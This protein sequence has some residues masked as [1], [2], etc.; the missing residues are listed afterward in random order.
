VQ[1]YLFRV[2]YT[3]PDAT[4]SHESVCVRADNETDAR[5][6]VDEATERYRVAAGVTKALTL[7][8]VTADV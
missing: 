5:T 1:R 2:T 3:Y 7:V 6:E 8:L 4:V